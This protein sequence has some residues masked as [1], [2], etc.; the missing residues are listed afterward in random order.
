MF[1]LN[2]FNKA[3]WY[4]YIWLIPLLYILYFVDLIKNI[5]KKD[6]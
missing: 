4:D 5:I 3:K 1:G 6:K 2:P